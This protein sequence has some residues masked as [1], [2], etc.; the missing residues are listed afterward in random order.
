VA[1]RRREQGGGRLCGQRIEAVVGYCPF[2]FLEGTPF[3]HGL[4]ASWKKLT[5]SYPKSAAAHR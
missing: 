1:G 3:F 4:H 2:M 5:R